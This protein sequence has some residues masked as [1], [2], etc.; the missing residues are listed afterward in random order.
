MKGKDI[1]VES[2]Y[3]GYCDDPREMKLTLELFKAC[4]LKVWKRSARKQG[5]RSLWT[6]PKDTLRAREIR[7]GFKAGLQIRGEVY[8]LLLG[9][10]AALNVTH[11]SMFNC[12]ALPTPNKELAIKN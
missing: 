5:A 7:R 10:R 3:V 12:P 6:A 8:D 11:K 4:G 2:G 9:I 1:R